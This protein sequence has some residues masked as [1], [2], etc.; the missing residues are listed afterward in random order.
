MSDVAA[1]ADDDLMM[2]MTARS[3]PRSSLGSSLAR[4]RDLNGLAAATAA[5]AAPFTFLKRHRV[6]AAAALRLHGQFN[7]IIIINGL[8]VK[9]G[10]WRAT[11]PLPFADS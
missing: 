5:A 10:H 7:G 9:I 11:A 4:S 2:M 6:V 1:A 8:V 3:A